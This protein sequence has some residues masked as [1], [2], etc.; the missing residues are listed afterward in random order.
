MKK[1][2]GSPGTMSGLFLRLGQCATAAASIGVMVSSYDFSNYTAFC[3]LVASMGLQLIWSFGL[4]CIDVYA[5]RRKSDLRSPI[6][7]S[8]FTVGD[9]V[10]ALLALAAACSSAGVTVLFTKDTEFC[11]QQPALSCDRFQI[12]VG[13]SFFNWFLAAISSHTMFWILI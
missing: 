3:F 13:L 4:A 1:M 5:I 9:W 10:T 12:S 7:L 2:I 8:L 6:L 11:R